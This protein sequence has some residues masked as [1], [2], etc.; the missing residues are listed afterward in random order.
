MLLIDNLFKIKNRGLI[1]I[2]AHGYLVALKT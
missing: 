1:E 2:K